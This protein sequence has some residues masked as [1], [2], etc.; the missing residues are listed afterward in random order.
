MKRSSTVRQNDLDE[1][2]SY[3]SDE[4]IIEKAYRNQYNQS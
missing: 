4:S 2:V 3:L 1:V